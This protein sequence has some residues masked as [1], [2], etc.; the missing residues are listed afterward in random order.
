MVRK[1]NLN[2]ST[3]QFLS[4]FKLKIKIEDEQIGRTFSSQTA[5]RKLKWIISKGKSL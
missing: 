4:N 1:V 5:F 3:A 2:F